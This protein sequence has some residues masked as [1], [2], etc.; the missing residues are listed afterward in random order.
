MAATPWPYN[1]YVHVA[2]WAGL[3]AAELCG[4]KVGDVALPSK[5]LNANSRLTP[6]GLSV[7]RVLLARTWSTWPRRRTAAVGGCRSRRIPPI[8]SATTSPYHPRGDDAEAPLFSGMVLGSFRP[9]GVRATTATG[10]LASRDPTDVARRQADALAGLSV[11][12]AEARLQLNWQEPLRHMTFYKAVFRPAVLRAN[13]LTP[14]AQLSPE[15]KFHSLRHTYASLC[16]AAGLE[17]VEVSRFM[18]H[19]KLTT[20]LD[21][22]THLFNTDDHASAMDKLGGMSTPV[23]HGGNVIPLR[24]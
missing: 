24:G 16:V 14:T 19:A 17:L 15:L 11:D 22:Y 12:D 18:G 1:V 10:E 13:R 5:S 20:T 23:P 21:I 6:D 8:S 7:R 4:L 2:A 9:T 3:R